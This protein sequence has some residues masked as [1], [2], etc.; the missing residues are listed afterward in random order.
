MNLGN[1]NSNKNKPKRYNGKKK[2]FLEFFK[3]SFKTIITLEVI[4]TITFSFTFI[5]N[6]IYFEENFN[7]LE[8]RISKVENN[9]ILQIKKDCDN[10]VLQPEIPI[11]PEE[12]S[13][14]VYVCENNS[15]DLEISC[16]E[17][18]PKVVGC[19]LS[20]SS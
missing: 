1:K 11:P 2:G 16:N 8:N 19:S 7:I 14:R 5:I 18:I 9:I 15:C 10:C 4:I 20:N 13:W 6:Y 3:P 17:S 12:K